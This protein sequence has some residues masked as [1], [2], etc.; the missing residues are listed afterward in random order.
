M[1]Q[2]NLERLEELFKPKS[3]YIRFAPNEKK[4]LIFNANPETAHEQN[5]EKYGLR[6]RFIVVDVTDPMRP[7]EN[8]IWDVSPRWAKMILSWLKK[9][10]E[11]LEITREGSGTSTNYVI[12]PASKE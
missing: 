7:E 10:Q 11:C 5:D 2:Q 1:S 9:N 6:C 3:N 8:K 4:T 12:M